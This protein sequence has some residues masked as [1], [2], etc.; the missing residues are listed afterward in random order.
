[1][2]RSRGGNNVFIGLE[3]QRKEKSYLEID[4]TISKEMTQ[5]S[6]FM[7]THDHTKNSLTRDK[8]EFVVESVL[9]RKEK[10]HLTTGGLWFIQRKH[11]KPLA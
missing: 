9:L 4:F 11:N 3:K 7:H 5:W 2:E 10:Q 8:L 1:M 6:F